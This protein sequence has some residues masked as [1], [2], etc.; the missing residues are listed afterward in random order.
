MAGYAVGHLHDVA[1]GPAIVEY[2]ERID[3]TLEP[4]GG[5][6]LIHGAR[7]DVREGDW[8]GDLI[9]IEFPDLDSARA[10][11]DS[12]AYREIIPLRA[13]N[14]RGAILLIDGAGDDHRA[15]DVLA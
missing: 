4:Y 5:R 8:S 9:L 6:F 13:E 7:P 3:A 10:W 11:Y 1:A 12:P 2:L 15:T 14:S